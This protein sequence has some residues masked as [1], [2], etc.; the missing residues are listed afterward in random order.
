[1]P[2]A[3]Y[4]RNSKKAVKQMCLDEVLALLAQRCSNAGGK[5]AWAQEV[6][7]SPQYVSDVIGRR[8]DPGNAILRPL[9]IEKVISYR[10]IRGATDAAVED[11]PFVED[12][13]YHQY[14][15]GAE[16]HD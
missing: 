6:G 7:V 15:W 16:S 5:A 4:I 10:E 12:G 8:R 9:G 14:M 13:D 2:Q 3:R 11:L 1:M